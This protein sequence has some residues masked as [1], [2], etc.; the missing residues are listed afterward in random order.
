MPEPPPTEASLRAAMRDPRYWQ[1]G[2]PE[3]SRYVARVTEG[4]RNLVEAEAGQGGVV[5]VRG[6]VRTIDGKAVNVAAHT[7]GP[8]DRIPEKVGGY[9]ETKQQIAPLR[10]Q[11]VEALP[12]MRS[13][14]VTRRFAGRFPCQRPGVH[15]GPV[16][17]RD[18]RSAVAGPLSRLW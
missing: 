11:V 6:Y 17:W 16:R 3:R 9:S 1:P 15:V 12:A 13:S 4:W 18:T 10:R 5:N 7:R 2:H 8:A 14:S